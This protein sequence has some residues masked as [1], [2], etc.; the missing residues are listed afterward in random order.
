MNH[1]WVMSIV[2]FCRHSCADPSGTKR[3][4]H[5]QADAKRH[6]LPVGRRHRLSQGLRGLAQGEAVDPHSLP[7]QMLQ[8]D[9]LQEDKVL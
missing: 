3:R 6:D 7:R 2:G 8:A 1:A 9:V 5:F 4:G